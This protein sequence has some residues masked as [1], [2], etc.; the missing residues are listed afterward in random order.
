[1]T[2]PQTFYPGVGADAAMQDLLHLVGQITSNW[3]SV[4]DQIFQV[5]VVALSGKWPMQDIYIYRSAFFSFNSYEQKMR[6]VDSAMKAR[7]KDQADIIEEWTKLKNL[8]ID[9]LVSVT[10]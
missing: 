8:W 5:F 3:A 2:G 9:F 10:K 6:M 7:F 4:E 1:M